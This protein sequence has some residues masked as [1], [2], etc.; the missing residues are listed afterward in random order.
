MDLEVEEIAAWETEA[1]L[2]KTFV[3]GARTGAS[4]SG[5]RTKILLTVAARI[6]FLVYTKRSLCD[7]LVLG[8]SSACHG[9]VSE[10]SCD[11]GLAFPA[12]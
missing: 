10:P 2:S 9:S 8:E 7:K 3:G 12:S 5:F 4:I 11:L 6:P 1:L